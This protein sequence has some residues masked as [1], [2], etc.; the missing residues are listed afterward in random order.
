MALLSRYNY[1][2]KD[3]ND[4]VHVWADCSQSMLDTVDPDAAIAYIRSRNHKVPPQFG[5]RDVTLLEEYTEAGLSIG[6]LGACAMTAATYAYGF[7]GTPMQELAT[8]FTIGS[9]ASLIGTP[10]AVCGR[11]MLADRGHYGPFAHWRAHQKTRQLR[12]LMGEQYQP[13]TSTVRDLQCMINERNSEQDSS[14]LINPFDTAA[15]AQVVDRVMP[16]QSALLA[17]Y[18][19]SDALRD[20]SGYS[21][22]RQSV[23]ETL[24]PHLDAVYKSYE[25]HDTT[26]STAW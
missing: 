1:A 12:K 19:I 25:Q 4:G 21:A 10:A 17:Q 16:D 15:L 6:T 9:A 20:P 26:H 3:I 24:S 22:L 14:I 7:D 5:E 13:V 23:H 2:P 8:G 11:A 18:E